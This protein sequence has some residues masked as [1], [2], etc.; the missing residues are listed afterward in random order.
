MDRHLAA[1][2]RRIR[3]MTRCTS[4]ADDILQEVQLKIWR[5]LGSYRS[6]ASFRTWMTRVAI[7]EALQFYRK[8]NRLP[9]VHDPAELAELTSPGESPLQAYVRA[10]L[11]ERLKAAVER[12]PAKHKQ[13]VVLYNLQERTLR[14]TARELQVTTPA[15]KTQIFRAKAALS[16]AMLRESGAFRSQFTIATKKRAGPSELAA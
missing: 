3:G 5:R 10:E 13:V 7:N 12:L 2:R 16:K 6:E 4:D 8:A 11:T 1:V 14:E 15:V 9:L